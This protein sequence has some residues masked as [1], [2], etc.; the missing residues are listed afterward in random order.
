MINYVCWMYVQVYTLALRKLSIF[1]VSPTDA[2][3]QTAN[4]QPIYRAH[5]AQM[6]THTHKA[7]ETHNVVLCHVLYLH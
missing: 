6:H 4:H 5:V 3:V 2:P 7:E 1:I